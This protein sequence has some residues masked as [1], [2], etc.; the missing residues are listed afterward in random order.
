MRFLLFQRGGGRVKEFKVYYVGAFVEAVLAF[1]NVL[2]DTSRGFLRKYQ[3][4]AQQALIADFCSHVFEPA[5][6]R[7]L[8]AIVVYWFGLNGGVST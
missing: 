3:V 5:Q 6:L 4:E 7:V 8:A 1:A 2:Q